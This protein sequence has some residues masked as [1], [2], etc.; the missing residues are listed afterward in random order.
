MAANLITFDAQYM[1]QQ[2]K[3]LRSASDAINEA[4][5]DLK[6]A[7][8]HERWRCR[9]CN[10]INDRLA[11]I[12]SFLG[13]LDGGIDAVSSALNTG[14]A[15]FAELESRAESQ[16]D[17]LG[18]DLRNKHGF[19]GVNYGSTE[20]N[21][22]LNLPV[23]LIPYDENGIAS[24][25]AGLSFLDKVK[26]KDETGKRVSLSNEAGLGKGVIEYF[27]A[28]YKLSAGDKCG[29]TGASDW[30]NFGDKSIGLWTEMHDYLRDENALSGGLNIVGDGFGFI[31][32]IFGAVDKINSENLGA[33]GTIGEIIGLGDNAV[34]FF[35]DIAKFKYL[36]TE[37]PNFVKGSGLYSPLDLWSAF[38]NTVISAGSQV[39]KSIEKYSADGVWDLG[40][41]AR[42]GIETGVSGLYTMFDKLSLGGLS[43]FGNI[44]GFTPENISRDI[45]NASYNFGQKIGQR[46]AKY[47]VDNPGLREAYNNAGSIG[48]TLITFHSAVQ[49]KIQETVSNVGN[50]FKSIFKF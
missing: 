31:S 48:K 33:A 46:A 44:T 45:E 30:F 18:N 29:F 7:S 9:E 24:A 40:D 12:K 41:T 39:F 10:V 1:L 27:E 49:S 42:T 26:I 3:V 21:T 19:D 6:R 22:N 8:L 32:D 4:A 47:I 14:A 23:T 16:A 50:L 17:G 13:K 5:S 20:N 15:R 36:G 2:A 35:G 25:K 38:G 43:A 11:E 34:D 28:L 37:G